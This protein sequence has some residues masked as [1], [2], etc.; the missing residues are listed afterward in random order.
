VRLKLEVRSPKTEVGGSSDKPKAKSQQP[1]KNHFVNPTEIPIFVHDIMTYND[2]YPFGALMPTRH[3]SSAGYRYG[4]N[5]K[6]LENDTDLDVYDYGARFYN[7]AVPFFWSIDPKADK[8]TFQSPYVYAQNN[9]VLYMDINGEG[10]EDIIITGPES[11]KTFTELQVSVSGQLSL[12]MDDNGRVSYDKFIGP[13]TEEAKQLLTAIDDSSIVVKVDASNNTTTS[14]GFPFVGGAF[15]GNTVTQELLPFE[16]NTVE[17]K[18]EINPNQLAT[19]S[20]FYGTPGKDVLHEITESYQGGVIAKKTGI[21]SGASYSPI[22]TYEAAHA[23]ATNQSDFYVENLD[24]KG[25]NTGELL[26]AGGTQ[27]TFVWEEGRP[28]VIIHIY[29]PAI[30][31]QSTPNNK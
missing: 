1:N 28:P 16:G 20:D 29:R 17:T 27:T 15:M 30:R 19:A 14:T 2:Y 8:Y 18:Q 4:Y 6:E 12:S 11:Q 10:T 24:R 5:G 21:S 25:N 3:E 9:P 23:A 13:L 22:N 7:P 26:F 31:T